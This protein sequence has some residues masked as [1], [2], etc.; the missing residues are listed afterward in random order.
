MTHI[1]TFALIATTALCVPAFAMGQSAAEADA[2]E[3]GMLSLDEVQAVYPGVS[4]DM[5][6]AAD[7]NGDGGLEDT[8][9]TAAQQAGLLPTS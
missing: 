6:A 2:N 8:E 5:F 1:K 9:V 3:D 4:A 7:L